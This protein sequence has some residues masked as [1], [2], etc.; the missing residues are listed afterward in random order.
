MASYNL[1]KVGGVLVGITAI[2]CLAIPLGCDT[3]APQ[4][5]G[6]E[7]VP[8]LDG[9]GDEA[10]PSVGVEEEFHALDSREYKVML[11]ADRFSG[12]VPSAVE[13]LESELLD[14]LTEARPALQSSGSLAELDK[15]RTVVFYDT[16]GDCALRA[17]GFSF[18]ERV[19][20]GDREVT[21][22]AR[23]SDRY[24]ASSHDVSSDRDGADSKFEEDIKQG[25][26]SVFSR[27]TKVEI[28][29]KN[30]NKLDDVTDLFPASA[31]GGFD[32]EAAIERVRLPVQ[33]HRYGKRTFALGELEAEMTVTLWYVSGDLTPSI[34]ELSF[35][36]EADEFELSPGDVAAGIMLFD[37]MIS[38]DGW[39]APESLTKT[40]WFY[41]TASFCDGSP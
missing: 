23:S 35:G 17:R 39:T 18:R 11:D 38:L 20:D 29:D 7:P 14:A 40:A 1:S 26:R 12:D 33:E 28:G 5:V 13:M 30:L 41:D 37:T 36:Y 10:G 3:P 2:M 9:K 15:E 22:K 4:S 34:A 24:I 21:L 19:E 32:Q 6:L 27:S 16:P 25:Y 31:W 8:T